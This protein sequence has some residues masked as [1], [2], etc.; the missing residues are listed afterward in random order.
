MVPN[1]EQYVAPTTTF[2]HRRWST[3]YLDYQK[4]TR[5]GS[6]KQTNSDRQ[7]PHSELEVGVCL[8]P[9]PMACHFLI[10]KITSTP[11]PMEECRGWS[12]ILLWIRDHGSCGLIQTLRYTR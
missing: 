9:A 6:W 5:H 7:F 8:L 2:L 3:C 12:Y 1:P 10:I 11:P 4:M